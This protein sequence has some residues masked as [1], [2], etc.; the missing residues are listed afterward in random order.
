LIPREKAGLRSWVAN[1]GGHQ[2]ASFGAGA[3]NATGHAISGTINLAI[4]AAD[5]GAYQPTAPP[6]SVSNPY[7]CNGGFYLAGGVTAGFAG[8]F[9]D[10]EA[11]IPEAASGIR[12]VITVVERDG[13]AVELLGTTSNGQVAVIATES[14]EGDTLFLSGLHIDGPGRGS[15][16]IGDLRALARQYGRDQ[17]VSRVVIQGAARSTGRSIGRV[18][19]EIVIE[20]G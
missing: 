17:G 10:P 13:D 14:R 1:H 16:G 5:G 19:S 18:P 11:E 20:V 2:V 15:M 12:A 4:K 6:L 7:P 8:F 9:I 3:A